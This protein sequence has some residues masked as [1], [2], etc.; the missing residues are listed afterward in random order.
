MVGGFGQWG[1]ELNTYT[2]TYSPEIVK[3]RPGIVRTTGWV[4]NAI[5]KRAYI[6]SQQIERYVC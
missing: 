3:L 5:I 2:L 1:D 4:S 6:Q